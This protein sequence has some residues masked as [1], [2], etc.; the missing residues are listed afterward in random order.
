MCLLEGK[1]VLVCGC[2][3]KKPHMDGFVTEL[4]RRKTNEMQRF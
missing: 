4:I 3:F 2:S 1:L